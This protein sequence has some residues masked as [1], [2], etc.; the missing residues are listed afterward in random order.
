VL[1]TRANLPSEM[2]SPSDSN[3]AQSNGGDIRFSSDSAGASRLALDVENWAQDSTHGAAD[4]DIRLHVKVPTLSASANTVIYAWY[5][6]LVTET[7]P[8]ATDTY[9]SK[10]AYDA[11]HCHVWALNESPSATPP[12]YQ[13]RV[14]GRHLSETGGTALSPAGKNGG[15]AFDGNASAYGRGD[16]AG[17][18]LATGDTNTGLCY[19]PGDDRIAYA[20]F[21]ASPGVCQVVEVNKTTGAEISRWS[22]TQGEVEIQG[23]AYDSVA[24]QFVL[25]PFASST[26]YFY[27]RSGTFDR[28]LNVSGTEQSVGYDHT[29]DAL[30]TG[31]GAGVLKKFNKTTGAIITTLTLTGAAASVAVEGVTHNATSNTLYVSTDTGAMIYEIDKSTGATIQ[32]FRG[33]VDIEHPAYDHTSGVLWINAD[34][35]FHSS[36]TSGENVI[37]KLN[38]NGGPF[39]WRAPT[40]E[41]TLEMWHKPDALEAQTILFANWESVQSGAFHIELQQLSG[42]LRTYSTAVVVLN[43]SGT[44]LVVGTWKHLVSRYT[45]SGD[46]LVMRVN[47]STVA[48]LTSAAGNFGPG[49]RIGLGGRPTNAFKH[50]GH[51]DD[52]R[53]HKVS[54]S[55]DWLTARYN[56]TNSPSAF[57]SFGTPE[58]MAVNTRRRRF[59]LAG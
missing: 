5:K 20:K 14:G 27:S 32:S 52:V 22:V 43:E 18:V 26:K 9:G 15:N 8:A 7:Q 55:D 11:N 33:P 51:L 40:T 58:A 36:G 45:D 38:P 13:D 12:E 2:A 54:R 25:A 46:T 56:N 49:G 53:L 16:Y 3:R 59:L 47:N 39:A 42:K 23:L 10:N 4:A 44:S 21:L 1:L 50:N 48:T 57:A 29:D 17:F 19:I 37:Y 24:N 28:S 6:P 41:Y 31:A 34:G 30:W 35:Y